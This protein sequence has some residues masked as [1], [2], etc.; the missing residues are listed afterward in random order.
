MIPKTD[1]WKMWEYDWHGPKYPTW[2]W[3]FKG[4]NVQWCL[5]GKSNGYDWC[6]SCR[7][8]TLGSRGDSRFLAVTWESECNNRF[9]DDESD[10]DDDDEEDEDDEVDE[11]E[12][13]E[14]EEE[15][16][17]EEED[18]DGSIICFIICCWPNCSKKAD[19]N[20][21]TMKVTA[22]YSYHEGV[23]P[24]PHHVWQPP[25]IF[26]SW[27]WLVVFH[28]MLHWWSILLVHHPWCPYEIDDHLVIWLW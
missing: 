9:D 2:K 20:P 25:S 11:D 15:D 5:K 3:L 26:C 24:F 4:A 21:S 7:H 18:D 14:A 28:P 1:G 19:E 23:A 17:D 10:E 22:C 6:R 12:D 16:E 27:I 13:Y 8:P